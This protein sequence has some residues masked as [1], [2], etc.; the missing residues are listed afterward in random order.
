METNRKKQTQ[1]QKRLFTIFTDVQ[2]LKVNTILR[3]Y[4]LTILKTGSL[5]QVE[6]IKFSTAK[7]VNKATWPKYEY[8]C[9]LRLELDQAKN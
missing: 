3:A 7:N 6:N 5:F 1:K 2:S 9:S 4:L 8:E